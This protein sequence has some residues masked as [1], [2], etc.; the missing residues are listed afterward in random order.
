M[1]YLYSFIS[2]LITL[3]FIYLLNN[4]IGEKVPMPLGAFLSPQTGFLKN[5]TANSHD[6]SELIKNN[7][8][9]DAVNVYLDERLVPHVFAQNE[10]DLYFVQ[11]FLHAKFRLF[12]MDLQTLVAAGRVS[13]IAGKKAL[14]LDRENRRLGMTFAAENTLKEIEKHPESLAKYSAYTKGVNAYIDQLK[15]ADY[16]L[17]Y[18]ILNLKPEHWSNLRTC[19]LLKM[20]AKTLSYGT[21]NDLEFTA[22]KNFFEISKLETLFPQIDDSLVPIIPKGTVFHQTVF[23]EKPQSAD[24][25]YL[26]DSINIPF[27]DQSNKP[28]HNNGSN[29]WVVAGSKT[30][31]GA[32]ILCND[33]HLDM[34]LPSIWY[35]IQL[36]TPNQNVYG[37]SIPGSPFVIIGFND[38]ISWG[39]TN[40]QRDVLD[41]YSIQF[42]DDSKKEYWYDNQWQPSA[43]RVETIKIKGGNDYFDTVAYTHFGPVMYDNSF[44]ADSNFKNNALAVK[45][46]AHHTGDDGISF[47]KLNQAKNY[48]D[49]LEAI[50]TYESPGQNFAFASKSGDIAIR[51]QGKF[52]ARWQQQGLFVMPGHDNSYDWQYFIPQAE[53]PHALNPTRGFLESANQRP[54]DQSYPYFIPG[55]YITPRGQSIEQ[56]L[57]RMN[58]ITVKDMQLLQFD[59]YSPLAANILPLMFQNL[60]QQDLNSQGR[61]YIEALKKWDYYTKPEAIATTIYQLWLNSLRMQLYIDEYKVQVGDSFILTN[62]NIIIPSEETTM[63]LMKKDTTIAGLV[64]DKTTLNKEENLKDIVTNSF[65][66]IIPKLDSLALIDKL[67]WTKYKNVSIYHLLKTA[68]PSFART[69]LPVGGWSNTINAVTNVHGPS[70]RM[71][72]HMTKETEAYGVYPGGQDGNPGS[73]YYDSFIDDWVAGKYYKL[74]MMKSSDN[75]SPEVKWSI[76]FRK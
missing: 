6:F 63:E 19:L 24:N 44:V 18:K 25:T 14:N 1:R 61:K 74:W 39:V 27:I 28:N 7:D 41:F 21:Q 33:P 60:R 8:L 45:W 23:P 22:M 55:S 15:Y 68:M 29:N 71:I 56:Q 4:P 35:E 10:E 59:Y 53:N 13:E 11:G 64:D 37:A 42:K 12:Q 49:Y 69:G 50:K 9:K 67:Q 58:N 16:P 54:V 40:A 20:M 62:K 73:K 30:Q 70:W 51:Q 72:V 31:S 5:A 38:S 52:P 26:Q 75:K 17:E 57:S 47:F 46:V 2:A 34:S 43:I 32:P 65:I 3:G 66:S 36:N 48:N 76:E